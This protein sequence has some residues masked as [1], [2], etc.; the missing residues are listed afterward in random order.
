MHGNFDSGKTQLN[1]FGVDILEHQGKSVFKA[2]ALPVCSID[3][4][5]DNKAIQ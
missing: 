5:L 3:F 1:H 2:L 4:S